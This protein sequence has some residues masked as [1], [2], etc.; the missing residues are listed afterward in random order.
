VSVPRG[1]WLAT[2]AT[3]TRKTTA[4]SFLAFVSGIRFSRSLQ[5]ANP[6]SIWLKAAFVSGL[7]YQLVLSYSQQDHQ[8]IDAALSL[9][10]TSVES[11][12]FSHKG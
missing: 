3:W 5:E 1:Q 7:S 4:T 10:D 11:V 2:L 6:L 9:T 12:P 8:L